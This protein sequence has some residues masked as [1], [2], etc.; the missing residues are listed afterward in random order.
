MVGGGISS[1]LYV[2]LDPAGFGCQ[3]A[4]EVPKMGRKRG[5]S[6]VLHLRQRYDVV[7]IATGRLGTLKAA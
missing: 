1:F 5:F 2:R 6:G 7:T 3:Y 4:G